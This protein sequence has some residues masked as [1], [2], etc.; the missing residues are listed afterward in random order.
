MNADDLLCFTHTMTPDRVVGK[1]LL[2]FDF[3]RITGKVDG[4]RASMVG[5]FKCDLCGYSVHFHAMRKSTR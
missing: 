3:F 1:Q 5:R 2:V 4:I